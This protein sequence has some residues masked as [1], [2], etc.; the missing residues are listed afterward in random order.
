MPAI[1]SSS[2]R[3]LSVRTVW[4]DG[5]RHAIL[6]PNDPLIDPKLQRRS[7]ESRNKS[8]TPEYRRIGSESGL[9]RLNSCFSNLH[10]VVGNNLPETKSPRM[11]RKLSA[12]PCTRLSTT[13]SNSVESME[14][15]QKLVRDR[16]IHRASTGETERD[17]DVLVDKS[18][19]RGEICRRKTPESEAD[20][21]SSRMERRQAE[22]TFDT[23]W[24]PLFER[25]LQ[26]LD[27]SGRAQSYEFEEDFAESSPRGEERKWRLMKKRIPRF[28]RESLGKEGIVIQNYKLQKGGNPEFPRK[29]ENRTRQRLPKIRGLR[30]EDR[31]DDD[32]SSDVLFCVS[33]A[34]ASLEVEEDES[35]EEVRTRER[36]SAAWSPPRRLQLHVVMPNL[37]CKENTSSQESLIAD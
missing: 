1:W 27:L 33:S 32:T 8:Y 12:P 26:W 28:K 25:V 16:R 31:N 14:D 23:F 21:G 36:V 37:V 3:P 13:G 30:D 22:G 4:V 5:I 19:F 17:I 9:D 15:H 10:V 35:K 11:Y 18:M 20:T 34:K 7:R 6:S 24:N 29:E 2:E